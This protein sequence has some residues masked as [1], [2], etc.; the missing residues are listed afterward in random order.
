MTRDARKPWQT[1][2]A[3]FSLAGLIGAAGWL[4]WRTQPRPNDTIGPAVLHATGPLGPTAPDAALVVT[5]YLRDQPEHRIRVVRHD[6]KSGRAQPPETLWEGSYRQF[7]SLNLQPI[8]ANR[9]LVAGSGSVIDLQEKALIHKSA[10]RLME[11]RG[12]RVVSGVHNSGKFERPVAFNLRTRAIEKLAD[13]EA[14]EF[15]MRSE[16]PEERSPDGMKSVT[17]R[18]NVLTLVHVGHPSKRLGT[19]K[20]GEHPLSPG[21]WLD[22]ER[23]LTQDG[24]G[25]LLA[26]GLDGVRVPVVQ[27][28]V[29]ENKNDWPY[30]RRDA[31]GRIIYACGRERFLIDADAKTWERCEWESLGHGFEESSL[32]DDQ[33]RRVYRYKGTEIARSPFWTRIG[34]YE[35]LATDGYIAVWIEHDLCVWSAG[36]GHWTTLG[37]HTDQIAGWLK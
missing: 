11:V 22:N 31:D 13:H 35:A 20:V 18:E 37:A 2:I 7:G 6:F 15:M 28:P 24:S 23:F 36:T 14:E 19:F 4:C 26:V 27:I 30:L 12:G 16:L 32:G 17:V 21:L 5:E 9:Y 10:G 1:R 29:V 3:L 8:I 33:R 25:N 34:P